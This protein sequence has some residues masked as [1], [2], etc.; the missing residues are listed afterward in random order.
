M[1]DLL[2]RN[3]VDIG[4]WRKTLWLTTER[5]NWL[6]FRDYFSVGNMFWERSLD[7]KRMKNHPKSNLDNLPP[8]RVGNMKKAIRLL[9]DLWFML[10][11]KIYF[12]RVFENSKFGHIRRK[13]LQALEKCRQLLLWCFWDFK[14]ERHGAN[15][16]V[17]P[18]CT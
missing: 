14:F 8:A 10:P 3:V 16:S 15:I 1:D 9:S 5:S 11:P 6:K 12:L 7:W 18:V 4:D 17:L 13:E 2:L